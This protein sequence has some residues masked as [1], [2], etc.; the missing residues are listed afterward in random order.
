MDVVLFNPAPT[1]GWHVYRRVVLP[2]GLVYSATPLDHA[3]YRVSIVDQFADRLWKQKLLKAL[4]KKPICFGVTSM[5]G[6]QILHALAACK[7]VK[8]KYPDLPIV[9]GGIHASLLPEQTLENPYVDVVVVG[10]GEVTLL[11]LVKALEGD[12]PLNRVA[13][14][15]YREGGRYRFTGL[16]PFVDL[17]KQPP[18]AFHLINMRRHGESILGVDHIHLSCSRGCTMD[19]AFCWNPVMHR[20]RFR[21]MSAGKVLD[22][23]RRVMRDYGLRGFMFSDDN[24]FI[25]MQRAYDILEGV[26]RSGLNIRIGNLNIRAD[27]LC[28]MDRDFL[29]LMVRA[30]VRRVGIGAES[31]SQRILELIKKR[32]TIDQVI[33]ANRKLSPCPIRPSYFFMMGLPTETPEEFAQSLHL[34]DRLTQENPK[35]TRSFK[36]YTPYPGTELFNLAVQSGLKPPRRLQDWS[37]LNFVNVL[38][39]TP[40]M[41]PKTK[42]LVEALNFALM[43]SDHNHALGSFRKVDPVTA[44]LARAYSPLASYRIRHLNTN[45]PI[46]TKL[47]NTLRFF[48]GRDL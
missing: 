47:I 23:M 35:A 19:C 24:F 26:V 46:E 11:E 37:Q 2:I 6:P 28:R 38:P 39:Q 15:A 5:T 13:G 8:K 31:G 20:R 27:T 10:E 44:A 17:D 42:K 48:M 32:I 7:L 4:A 34:A 36:V 9:W 43:C 1:G 21:K 30:G 22:I 40:W 3:G 14:I 25:D 29:E 12:Q 16:R 18:P 41:L 45:F 33:E